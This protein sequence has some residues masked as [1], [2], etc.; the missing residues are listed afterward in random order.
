VKRAFISFAALAMVSAM[1]AVAR[2][3]ISNGISQ[4]VPP[5]VPGTAPVAGFDTGYLDHHPEVARELGRN[6]GLVDNP[7]FLATHPGLDSY[8]AS[9][10]QIRTELQQHPERFMNAEGNYE[11][12]E[13]RSN[14]EGAV[15]RFDEGYLDKHPEVA[16]E[17]SRNPR[18]AD[19]PQFLAS[20]PGLQSYLESHPGVRADLQRN[21]G[22]FMSAER[23]YE[24]AEGRHDYQ[25]AVSRF[26]EGYLDQHPEVARELSRNPRLADNPQFLA[27]HPGLQSYLASH[28][29][30]RADLQQHPYRFM[31]AES[32]YERY[33]NGEQGRGRKPHPFNNGYHGDAW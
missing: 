11:R 1:V 26:D 12:A 16:R 17:L 19:D 3:Q 33:E 13:N 28:P 7:Q 6:P 14:F 29:G 25:S 10:P 15:S 22:H 27:S 21:P 2:A 5:N 24:R 4:V 32:R 23:N 20:H 31:S 9:H 18:L 30:V 8:L